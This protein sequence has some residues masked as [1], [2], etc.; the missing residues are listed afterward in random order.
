MSNHRV[1]MRFFRSFLGQDNALVIPVPLLHLLESL[2]GALLL[3]QIIFWSDKSRNPDGWF[4]KSFP[5]WWREIHLSEYHVKKW[6]EVFVEAGFLQTD[7]RLV[8]NA[9]TTHYRINLDKFYEWLL[10]EIRQKPYFLEQFPELQEAQPGET[11]TSFMEARSVS[12]AEDG[13]N[14]SETI[15]RAD[16][17]LG[18]NPKQPRMKRSTTRKD[19]PAP[20]RSSPTKKDNDTW[21]P[22][23]AWDAIPGTPPSR[24]TAQPGS[25]VATNEWA[26]QYKILDGAPDYIRRVSYL[27]TEYTGLVPRGSKKSWY[28]QITDLWEAARHDESILVRGLVKGQ[29]GK[30][31]RGLTMV[32]PAS[33]TSFVVSEAA[34]PKKAVLRR[35]QEPHMMD[36][37]GNLI[38][39]ANLSGNINFGK[40]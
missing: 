35:R 12:Q 2:E 39:N 1:L 24:S 32:R 26:K 34:Q 25:L 14:H 4:Y 16:N 3:N 30:M 9:P 21:D 6:T 33:F 5:E 10:R 13:G 27:L 37:E 36:E 11:E 22:D 29:E 28:A 7:V 17:L 40:K 38:L 20:K 18:D 8:H 23:A 19:H 31:Q 15:Q